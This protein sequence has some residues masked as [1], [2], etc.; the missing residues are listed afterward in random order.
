MNI[1][2]K[3]KITTLKDMRT[4]LSKTAGATF[5][6]NSNVTFNIKRLSPLTDVRKKSGVVRAV[7]TL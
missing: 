5:Y 3:F 1:A 4:F 6:S 7:L 2:W